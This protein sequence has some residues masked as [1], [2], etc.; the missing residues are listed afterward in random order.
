MDIVEIILKWAV[1]VICGGVLGGCITYIKMR[2]R[3]DRAIEIGVQC[4]LRAEIIA[5]YKEYQHKHYCPIYAKESLKRMYKAYH[6]LGG[7]DVATSLYERIMALPTESGDV[8]E[9]T[10]T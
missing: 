2:K 6:D 10:E 8:L 5:N 1:P 7:N 9:D 4:L 3:K